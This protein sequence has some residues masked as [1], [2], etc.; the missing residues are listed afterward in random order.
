VHAVI[1]TYN[2]DIVNSSHRLRRATAAS[3]AGLLA[4]AALALLP[5]QALRAAGIATYPDRPIRLVVPFSVGG[6]ADTVARSVAQ[7]MGM[8]MKQSVI[9]D[10]RAGGNSIIGSEFVARAQ[11]DGYTLLMQI[12]PPH[13]TLPFFTRNMP[14]DPVTD[15]TAIAMIG[16]APQALVVNATLPVNS[17]QELIAYAKAHPGELSYATSGIGSS[18]HLGGQLLNAIAG[19]D[20]MHVPYKGGAP[21]LNDVVGGQVPIGILV[22][23][24]VLPF[25]KTGKLKLLGVLEAQRAKAAPDTPTLAQAGVPGFAL[26]NTWVGLLGP[27]HMPAAL[28]DRLHAEVEKAI[29]TPAVRDQLDTAGFEVSGGSSADF[30][31]LMADST[32]VYQGI[33]QKAGIQPE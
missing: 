30:A 32:R 1:H 31:K 12:G 9:V 22:L 26:P 18:Q 24:N 17:V 5:G 29:A 20:L 15:F 11:P 13:T 27:A 21:A 7:R 28:V 10:N 4:A 25:V 23:S 3:A 19:I 8:D 16:T 14:Y 2:G 33:V 6:A